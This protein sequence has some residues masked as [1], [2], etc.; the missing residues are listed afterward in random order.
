MI[1]K[2]SIAQVSNTVRKRFEHCSMRES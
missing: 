2:N 1:L